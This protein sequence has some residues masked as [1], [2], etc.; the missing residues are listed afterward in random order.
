MTDKP[1]RTVQ[2]GHPWKKVFD[3]EKTETVYPTGRQQKIQQALYR[4]D[5]KY[6]K[7]PTEHKNPS[8]KE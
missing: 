1:R 4:W 3:P 5:K 7:Y 6:S 2:I 8:K